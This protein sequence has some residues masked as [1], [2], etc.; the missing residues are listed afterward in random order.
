MRKKLI[1]AIIALTLALSCLVGVTVAWLYTSTDEVVNTFT[2][3]DIEISLT[4]DPERTFQMI[5]GVSYTKNPVVAVDGIKTNVD[6]YLFVKIEEAGATQWLEYTTTL[7]EANEWYKVP[8]ENNVWYRV[9]KTTDTL[10]EW[11]ILAGDTVKISENLTKDQMPT[12]N[13][14]LTF[15]AYAIQQVGFNTPEAAWAEASKLG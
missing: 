11:H 4:E 6:I 2:P 7:T 13:P 9:V 15:T 12:S 14:T 1:T 8:G 10:K 3:S 5:P